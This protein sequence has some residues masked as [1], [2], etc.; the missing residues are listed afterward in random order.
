MPRETNHTENSYKF[1]QQGIR[2][3]LRDA[4]FEIREAWKDSRDW[5]ALTLACLR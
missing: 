2:T 3:L 1:T 4:G 5:Y